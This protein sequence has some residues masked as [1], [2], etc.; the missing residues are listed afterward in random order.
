[1]SDLLVRGGLVV[2]G[3]GGPARAADVRV[4][5]GRRGAAGRA[6]GRETFLLRRRATMAFAAGMYVF[7]GGVRNS[8]FDPGSMDGRWA[9]GV[10]RV[11]CVGRTW[12]G[13]LVVAAV[14]EVFVDTGLLLAGA[15]GVSATRETGGRPDVS[16]V[17][18]GHVRH[19]PARP[20][21][22]AALRPAEPPGCT[23]SPRCS[24]RGDST[25]G[26][27]WLRFP[28]ASRPAC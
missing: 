6:A 24:S 11:C 26:S 9:S 20:R 7:S 23:E 18:S 25:P 28:S 2:D 8:D 3:T 12:P 13:R 19:V 17:A 10:G 16:G 22:V 5:G 21:P 1:M 4:R 14:R 15:G 27:S